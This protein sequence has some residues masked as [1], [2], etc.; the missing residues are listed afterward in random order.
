METGEANLAI[1]TL[2][3]AIALD[4]QNADILFWLGKAYQQ[5]KEYDQALLY[6]SETL[7]IDPKNIAAA[8]AIK[9]IKK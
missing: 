5:K 6:F 2:T 4:K 3:K 8:H 1:A 9:E 7:K